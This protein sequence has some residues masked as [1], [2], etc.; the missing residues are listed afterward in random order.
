MYHY[1]LLERCIPYINIFNF[2]NLVK[3]CL[4]LGFSLNFH[5]KLRIIIANTN[6]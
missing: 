2:E 4:I 5:A 1:Y 3:I 6:N